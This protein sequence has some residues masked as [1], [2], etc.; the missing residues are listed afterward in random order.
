MS[1]EISAMNIVKYETIISYYGGFTESLT[2]RPGR[3][4]GPD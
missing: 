1:T 3:Q 4:P 2:A